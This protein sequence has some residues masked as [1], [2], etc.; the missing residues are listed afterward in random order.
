MTNKKKRKTKKKFPKYKKKRR[1]KVL[2]CSLGESE[3][4]AAAHTKYGETKIKFSSSSPFVLCVERM[5]P[6]CCQSVSHTHEDCFP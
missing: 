6:E 5:T 4:Y 2:F 3:T 1:K